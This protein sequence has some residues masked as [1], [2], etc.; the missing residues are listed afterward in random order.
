MSE[1]KANKQTVNLKAFLANVRWGSIYSNADAINK[2][3]ISKANLISNAELL[4]AKLVLDIEDHF[5]GSD[6]SA[7]FRICNTFE[8]GSSGSWLFQKSPGAPCEEFN[9]KKRYSNNVMTSIYTDLTGGAAVQLQVE[10]SIERSSC[11]QKTGKCFVKSGK[12]NPV[13]NKTNCSSIRQNRFEGAAFI[14]NMNIMKDDAVILSNKNGKGI[15]RYENEEITTIDVNG[16]ERH[17]PANDFYL[18]FLKPYETLYSSLFT[19]EMFD[20]LIGKKTIQDIRALF[21][22]EN[23]YNRLWTQIC[24]FR[25]INQKHFESPMLLDGSFFKNRVNKNP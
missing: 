25:E 17:H 6:Q 1:R 5:V 2:Y 11:F 14:S 9:N 13:W 8:K 21:K 20:V 10:H 3:L 24:N 15:D 22:Q 23:E 16:K 18:N 7:L 12:V 4:L 19:D